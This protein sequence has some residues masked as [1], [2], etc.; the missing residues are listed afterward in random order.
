MSA[1]RVS[2]RKKAELDF[3]AQSIFEATL[4]LE[5]KKR[6]LRAQQPARASAES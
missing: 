1:V 3:I 5:T 4:A 6:E 2:K